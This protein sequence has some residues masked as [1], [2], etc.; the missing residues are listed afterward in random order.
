MTSLCLGVKYQVRF[1]LAAQRGGGQGVLGGA[2]APGNH[3]DDELEMDRQRT[4]HGR[5]DVRC[6]LAHGKA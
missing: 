1:G 4:A 3:D 2:F 6:Q 5:L